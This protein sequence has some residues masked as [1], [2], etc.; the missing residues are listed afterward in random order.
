MQRFH[1]PSTDPLPLHSQLH[2]Q[3]RL[4]IEQ[5][6]QAFLAEGGAIEEVGFQ[7]KGSQP[8]T[9]HPINPRTS[10]VY[11][12]LFEKPAQAEQPEAKPRRVAKAKPQ[13]K[14]EPI[15][16]PAAPAA[17]AEPVEDV[18]VSLIRAWAVLGWSPKRMAERLAVSEKHIRQICRQHGINVRQ[19]EEAP[20]ATSTRSRLKK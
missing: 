5:A 15:A 8:Y 19:R 18:P 14:A 3:E 1:D 2:E 17:V 7:M 6:T 12:H 9:S 20:W 13:P 11:A 16:A 10:P 4:R